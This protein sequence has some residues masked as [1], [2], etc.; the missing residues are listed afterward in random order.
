[1]KITLNADLQPSPWHS[2]RGDS[3]VTNLKHKLPKTNSYALV[4]APQIGQEAIHESYLKMMSQAYSGH[5]AIRVAPHDLWYIVLCEL[6]ATINANPDAFR[7]LFTTS[8]VKVEISVPT[9][10]PTYLPLD[11]IMNGLKRL[12]PS[13]TELFIP[14]FSTHT[15][16]SRFAC[17]AA[18]A[19]A[20]KSYYSYSTFMCGLPVVEF[21]GTVEDWEL[22]GHNLTEIA[23]LLKPII[24]ALPTPNIRGDSWGEGGE[25]GNVTS[26][27]FHGVLEQ[28]EK[29]TNMIGGKGNESFVQDI[30]S[31]KNVGSGGEKDVTGWI[32][33]FYVNPTKALKNFNPCLSIVPFKNL[34]TDQD[35]SVVYGSFWSTLEGDVRVAQYGGLTF[36]HDAVKPP[37]SGFTAYKDR[38]SVV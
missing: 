35:Y 25:T 9:F 32:A 4:T 29:I 16:G 7:D 22:F 33:K 23:L 15:E 24:D 6:A 12:V 14:D 20:V 18:F 1:M 38:K 17:Y 10:D 27:Y 2:Y 13:N 19:D 8:D 21:T 11:L 36:R 3:L 37:E 28:I 26:L 5:H 31:D 30:Y 34:D